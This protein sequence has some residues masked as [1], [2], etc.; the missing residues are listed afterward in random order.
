MSLYNFTINNNQV[1]AVFEWDDGRWEP[2]RIDYDETF[3]VS[4]NNV[5]RTETDRF[6][7][8]ITTYAP[9]P[10]GVGYYAVSEVK[11]PLNNPIPTPTPT[12]SPVVP[13]P[14]P[15]PNPANIVYPRADLYKF[16]FNGDQVVAAYEFDD[17][18]WELEFKDP[19]ETYSIVN[20]NVVLTEVEGRWTEITTYS[21]VGDG[22][23]RKVSET[24]TTTNANPTPTTPATTTYDNTDLALVRLYDAVFNRLPDVAGFK[25]WEQGLAQGL[26]N[27]E[28]VIA[29]FIRS[30]EFN[31]TYGN[32]TNEQFVELLYN[33]VLGRPSDAEGKNYWLTSLEN[34]SITREGLV[35]SFAQSVEFIGNTQSEVLNFL[36]NI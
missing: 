5:I 10:N 16:D 25:Y 32:T 15:T 22:T 13:T 21:A 24:Y 14:T 28:S 36:A 26:V 6:Y 7:K 3:E 11:V 9:A 29:S 33:N 19:N 35:D 20:G 27:W 12:P 1:T 17:G 30:D 18:R 8:E 23:Y 4:G 34:G 2:E 31:F